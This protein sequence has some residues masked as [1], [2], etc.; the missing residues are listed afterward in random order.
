[1][2]LALFNLVKQN[3]FKSLFVSS[4]I[5]VS[6]KEFVAKIDKQFGRQDLELE[7]LKTEYDIFEIARNAIRFSDSRK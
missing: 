6:P 3:A 2:G 4:D 7:E 5:K 1:M